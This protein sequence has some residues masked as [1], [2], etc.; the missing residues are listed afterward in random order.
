MTEIETYDT[1]QPGTTKVFFKVA[2]GSVAS[3]IVGN[4]AVSTDSGYQFYVDDY[5]AEQI[6]KCELYLEG[7][8]PKLRLKEGETLVI[9]TEVERK[10]KEIEELERKLKELKGEETGEEPEYET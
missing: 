1:R 7:F 3:V 8:T 2:D 6:D 5:V 4:Q 9:P 10:Q